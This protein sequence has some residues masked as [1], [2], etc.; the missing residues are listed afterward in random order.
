MF[1]YIAASPF[2]LQD[3]FGLTPQQFSA[4]FAANAAGIVIA[5]QLG[6]MLLRR[7]SRPAC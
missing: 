5:S 4:C 6:R 1:G 3:G 2:L 7:F